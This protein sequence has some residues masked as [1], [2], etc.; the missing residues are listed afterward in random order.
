MPS[1]TN[2]SIFKNA[3]ETKSPKKSLLQYRFKLFKKIFL[4]T[5]QALQFEK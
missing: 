4:R 3:I 2:E 5:I 1:N